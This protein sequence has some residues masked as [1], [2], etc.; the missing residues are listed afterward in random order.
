MN[1]SAILLTKALA[2][3]NQLLTVLLTEPGIP[4]DQKEM[5]QKRLGLNSVVINIAQIQDKENGHA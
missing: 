4:A 2:N 1:S 5:I 3:T